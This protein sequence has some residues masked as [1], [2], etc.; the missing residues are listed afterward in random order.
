M[1]STVDWKKAGEMLC[2]GCSFTEIARHFGVSRQRIQQYYTRGQKGAKKRMHTIPY[3][4][5]RQ[6]FEIHRVSYAALGHEVC[7]ESKNPSNSIRLIMIGKT[8]TLPISTA[9]KLIQMTGIP[10]EEMFRTEE[11]GR[12]Q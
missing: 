8:K 4:A 11:E 5:L 3:P 12:Q 2:E 9:K 6:W 1:E 10:F 7:P